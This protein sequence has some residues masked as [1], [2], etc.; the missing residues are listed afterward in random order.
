[1]SEQIPCWLLQSDLNF[2]CSSGPF[3]LTRRQTAGHASC[4]P[5]E[6][7]FP[8]VDQ[9]HHL[10]GAGQGLPHS[11]GLVAQVTAPEA[12]VD[13]KV[14]TWGSGFV[15]L[16][17]YTG[18][19]IPFRR[20]AVQLSRLRLPVAFFMLHEGT[21]WRYVD[22]LV[23]S[24]KAIERSLLPSSLTKK[25][26]FR[27]TRKCSAAETTRAGVVQAVRLGHGAAPTRSHCPV[28]GCTIAWTVFWGLARDTVP[29][30]AGALPIY[31]LR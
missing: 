18:V 25:I 23:C 29:T 8:Q 6:T 15:D 26:D 10:H 28:S 30:E 14:S 7:G 11:A 20:D 22:R 24:C 3:S 9:K 12:Q 19:F 5:S 16:W 21:L 17:L 4:E 2:S 13:L 1:M 27:G 31:K